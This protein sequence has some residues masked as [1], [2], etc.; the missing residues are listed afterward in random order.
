MHTGDANGYLTP[1]ETPEHGELQPPSP[2]PPTYDEAV[3]MQPL[4][5]LELF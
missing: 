4:D 2:P 5:E 1:V 3:E